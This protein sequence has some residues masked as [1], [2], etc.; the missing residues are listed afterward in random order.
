MIL[1]LLAGLIALWLS[2]SSQIGYRRRRRR[3]SYVRAV[4]FENKPEWVTR[5]VIRLKALMPEAGCRSV[6]MVFNRRHGVPDGVTVGKTW[7]AATLRR[8]RYEVRRLRRKMKHRIPRDQPPNRVWGLDL[9][10]KADSFGH[11]HDILAIVDHG[12]RA[13]L[14]LGALRSKASIALIRCL[15]DA[16]ERY[17]RPHAVR[18]DNEAVFTGA[19]FRLALRILGVRH[20]RTDIGCPW[21]N[22]RVERF[23][24][25]LK[26]RLDHWCVPDRPS[27]DYSLAVFRLWYNHIRP[28]QHLAGQTPAEYWRGT[29][30][31]RRSV[32]ARRWFSAWDGLLTGY[33]FP[34]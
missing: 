24:R 9:T 30:L 28:H 7:V 22:G 1:F 6:A 16:I 4:R 8:H 17:G 13:N 33:Y 21:M 34:T 26:S 3:P 29:Q 10:G 18:T 2:R 27:L 19:L 25:T 31:T 12:S 20:Q 5:K 11:P 32:R 23:F 14:S 15:L